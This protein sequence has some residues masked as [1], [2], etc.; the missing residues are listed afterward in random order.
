MLSAENEDV[1]DT[2][3]SETAMGDDEESEQDDRVRDDEASSEKTACIERGP[4][5]E[6]NRI[7]KKESV[8]P[9]SVIIACGGDDEGVPGF[10]SSSLTLHSTSLRDDPPLPLPLTSIAHPCLPT[11]QQLVPIR[12]RSTT[13]TENDPSR[14]S[15]SSKQRCSVLNG[16]SMVPAPSSLPPSPTPI[17]CDCRSDSS[18]IPDGCV[19]ASLPHKSSSSASS[20]DPRHRLP[21]TT[22]RRSSPTTNTQCPFPDAVFVKL[23]VPYC[24]FNSEYCDK[25]GICDRSSHTAPPSNPLEQLPN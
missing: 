20:N 15:V 24:M 23:L 12:A 10:F 18:D 2:E 14:C 3:T 1:S 6:E 7:S 8:C 17:T 5:N 11:S 25:V 16:A 21:T 19:V 4:Q 13:T 22:L 9:L